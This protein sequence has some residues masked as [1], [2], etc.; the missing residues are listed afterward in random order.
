MGGSAIKKDYFYTYEDY[1]KL[2]DDKRYEVINGVI[3]LLASGANWEHQ[4]ISSNL[5]REFSVY[6]KGKKCQVFHPPFDVILPKKDETTKKASSI[7]QPDIFVVCDKNKLNKRGCFGSP[8]LII[9]I[10]SPA[11][12]KKDIK[13]KFNLYQ[14]HGVPEYWIVDPLNQVIDRFLYDETLKEY[15]KPEYFLRD[16]TISPII[17]PDLKIKLD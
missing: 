7:I 6:L 15:K 14:E 5:H 12:S 16:D 4:T 11:T 13:E 3:Y 10:L 1:C 9:E 17:F 2:D 8:D